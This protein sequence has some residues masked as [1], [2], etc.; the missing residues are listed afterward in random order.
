L[1]DANGTWNGGISSK[2][3]WFTAIRPEMWAFHG[4]LQEAWYR[5]FRCILLDLN[6]KMEFGVLQLI[7]LKA[8]PGQV[9]HILLRDWV[10]NLGMSSMGNKCAVFQ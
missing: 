5:E 7:R 10:G 4:G 1:H 6:S 9:M 2:L 8:H 3:G